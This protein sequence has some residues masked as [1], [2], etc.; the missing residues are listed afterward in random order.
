M[1]QK[2]KNNHLTRRGFI[3]LSAAGALSTF[4]GSAFGKNNSYSFTTEELKNMKVDQQRVNLIGAYG[5]WAS[6]HMKK[7]V[8]ISFIQKTGME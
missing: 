4:A 5:N 6:E 7:R 2:T 3:G 1:A 8:A